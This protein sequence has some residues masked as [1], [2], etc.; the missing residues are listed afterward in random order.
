M[1]SK[2][3]SGFVV[4][5]Q[6]GQTTDIPVSDRLELGRGADSLTPLHSDTV[7]RKHAALSWNQGELWATDSGS[8]NGTFLNGKKLEP[9]QWRAVP[10]NSTL[11]LGTET[12]QIVKAQSQQTGLKVAAAAV[13][14]PAGLAIGLTLA[15][16]QNDANNPAVES[17]QTYVE[18]LQS[19]TNIQ[20]ATTGLVEL[21]KGVPTVV[22]SDIHGRRDFVM[23]ALQ[24]TIDIGGSEA[25]VFDLLTQKKINVVC[26]GDGMHSEARGEERWKMAE[27]AYLAGD[28]QNK[29]MEEEM[30]ENL[31]TMKMVMKLKENFPENF[32]FLRGNHDEVKGDFQKYTEHVGESVMV[33]NWMAQRFGNDFVER[34]AAFEESMPLMARGTGFVASHAAPGQELHLQDIQERDERAYQVLSWTE[35]R[36]WKEDDQARQQQFQRNLQEFQTTDGHWLVGHRPVSNG[37]YRAQMNDQLVQINDPDHFVVAFVP[38]DGKFDP[39]VNVHKL[40]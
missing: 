5:D 20:A 38:A 12:L 31:G 15:E 25:S 37:L 35:N 30:A 21:P 7:S 3:A 39:E 14:G 40:G 9:G 26:I 11:Q 13:G 22:L 29:L 17:K 36:G 33:R 34:W 24:S 23:K 4:R 6:Q 10:E 19:A 32:H 28:T 18:H 8:T 16:L 27:Q 1:G 2:V